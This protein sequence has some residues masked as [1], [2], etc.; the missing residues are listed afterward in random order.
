MAMRKY[1]GPLLFF[2]ISACGSFDYSPP[3]QTPEHMSVIH[4]P[5]L[6]W[7]EGNLHQCAVEHPEIALTIRE[8][9]FAELD[10]LAADVILKLG[11]PPED[12]VSYA[13]L[14]GWE[15]IVIV[16]NPNIPVSQLELPDLRIIYSSL[17]PSYQPWSY[18]ERDELRVIFDEVMLDNKD[19]SP[20][21]RIAPSPRAMLNIILGNSEA[22]GYIPISWL[23]EEEIKI[24]PVSDDA[25]SALRQP[26]LALTYDE[27]E[28][29]LRTYLACLT[30]LIAQS[31]N[32][33]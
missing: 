12:V 21:T 14:L 16:A 7:M 10:S 13:T 1:I 5:A 18:P 3:P 2:L 6:G 32:S 15:Q 8:Q 33:Q 19:I 23:D 17:E 11:T 24:V 27:P 25:A 29:A 30:V 20:H 31:G 28:G 4:T 22:V 9:P 26:I